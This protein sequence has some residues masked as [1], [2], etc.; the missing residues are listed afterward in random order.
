MYT[1]HRGMFHSIPAALVFGEAAF[2]LDGG[3][4]LGLRIF[5]AAAVS[6]GYLSH[7]VLDEIWSVEWSHG[8]HL[9]KSFGTALKLWGEGS[10]SNL[11]CYAKLLILTAVIF[12]EPQWPDGTSQP[13]VGRSPQQTATRLIDRIWHR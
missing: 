9:K 4:N 6:I 7:L 12:F 13:G 10:W 5:I 2:L 1:V 8:L 3:D 11:S